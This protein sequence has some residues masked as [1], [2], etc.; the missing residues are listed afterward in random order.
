MKMAKKTFVL[1][2]GGSVFV[3][4]SID[5]GF[6]KK[7]KVFIEQQ[8]KKGH[9][10]IVVAGGG[11][12]ARKYRDAGAAVV[13]KMPI[14]DLDWLGIH[15]TRLNAQLLRTIFRGTT[16]QKVIKD[17]TKKH[18]IKADLIIGAGYRP[19]NSTDYC[20]VLIAKNYGAKTVINLSNI[21][22]VY[23]KDPKLAGAK[24]IEKISW[25]EF[26]KIVGNKWDP[27]LHAPFDPIASKHAQENKL[28]V[29]VMNGKNFKNLENLLSGKKFKGTVIE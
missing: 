23:T 3:P 15:A 25:T 10:F 20:A 16:Y 7:F 12:T 24:K 19:G 21:D 22:Y 27:G 13:H 8:I 14:E 1:S 5:I 28:R 4:D 6:L 9:R 11:A 18:N 29:V 17:P 2:L 26:R